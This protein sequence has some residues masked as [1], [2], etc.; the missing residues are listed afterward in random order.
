MILLSKIGAVAVGG[1][2]EVGLV[3]VFAE[4]DVEDRHS[5]GFLEEECRRGVAAEVVSTDH[6]ASHE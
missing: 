6:Q 5:V 4:P 1:E 2:E 3:V